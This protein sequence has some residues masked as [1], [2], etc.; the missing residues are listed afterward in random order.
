[1][2]LSQILRILELL[3]DEVRHPITGDLGEHADRSG[4][5][6]GSGFDCVRA[7]LC[8]SKWDAVD[9]D[10]IRDVWRA[11]VCEFHASK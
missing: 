4:W 5:H 11:T 3:D 9:A 6:A 10:E 1:M 7:V 2:R 8:L